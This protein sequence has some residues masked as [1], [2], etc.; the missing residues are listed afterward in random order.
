MDPRVAEDVEAWATPAGG[1]QCPRCYARF[2]RYELVDVHWGHSYEGAV[3]E[4]YGHLGTDDL[5]Y[6]DQYCCGECYMEI[7]YQD[8]L[9]EEQMIEVRKAMEDRV[10]LFSPQQAL[11]FG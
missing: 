3:A 5:E 2:A 8:M 7:V 6:F 11:D 1:C 4:D 10:R 9:D